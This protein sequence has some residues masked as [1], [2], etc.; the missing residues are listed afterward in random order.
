MRVLFVL[1]GLAKLSKRQVS[2]IGSIRYARSSLVGE[3]LALSILH[4][5]TD[6]TFCNRVRTLLDGW[7]SWGSA[8][9]LV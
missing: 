4:I 6:I 7:L 1:G 3:I 2:K 5:Y 9:S 8:R